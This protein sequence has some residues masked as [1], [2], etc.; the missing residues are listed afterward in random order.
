MILSENYSWRYYLGE[1]VKSG[2]T[3]HSIWK[4]HYEGR[5]VHSWYVYHFD[6][7]HKWTKVI[8]ETYSPKQTSK[9]DFGNASQILGKQD[10]CYHSSEGPE[11]H[12]Y[13]WVDWQ[14]SNLWAQ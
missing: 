3:N 13:R 5:R 7:Y 14:S 2:Q 4:F 6:V 9:E 10:R 8:R 12:H 11:N 1:R